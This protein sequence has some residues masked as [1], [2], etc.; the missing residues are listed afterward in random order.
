[1][2]SV[3]SATSLRIELN[4]G[5]ARLQ[6]R[7]LETFDPSVPLRRPEQ[8][9]RASLTARPSLADRR[10]SPPASIR[11]R[12]EPRRPHLPSHLQL[13][14]PD[15]RPLLRLPSATATIGAEV[16]R[17]AVLSGRRWRRPV[18]VVDGVG[19]VFARV[20]RD[21]QVQRTR[22]RLLRL[23]DLRLGWRLLRDGPQG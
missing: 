8:R 23:H 21:G 10:C 12:V 2:G 14:D 16:A 19:I 9:T 18:A 17:L 20:A 3:P 7:L 11:R 22:R 6:Q 15:H 4:A 1:M 5:F 13:E